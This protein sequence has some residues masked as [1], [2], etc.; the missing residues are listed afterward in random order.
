MVT[1][2]IGTPALRADDAAE[3][4][5][6]ASARDSQNGHSGLAGPVRTVHAMTRSRII[7]MS[8]AVVVLLAV[9]GGVFWFLHDDSP[10]AVSLN[11]AAAVVTGKPSNRAVSTRLR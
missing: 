1:P 10:D 3:A 5:H 11:S 4:P 6:D 7:V 2:F 9:G 8:V